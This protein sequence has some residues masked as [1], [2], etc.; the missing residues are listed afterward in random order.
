MFYPGTYS[1]KHSP[2]LMHPLE[3]NIQVYAAGEIGVSCTVFVFSEAN[4][5]GKMSLCMQYHVM[6][7]KGSMQP[8]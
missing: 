7:F 5:S 2:F 1:M 6:F 3:I 4:T 8:P